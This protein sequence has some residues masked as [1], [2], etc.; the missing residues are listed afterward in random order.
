MDVLAPDRGCAAITVEGRTYHADRHG[1]YRGVP[2][3]HGRMMIRGGNAAQA[4]AGL[5]H[6]RGYLCGSCG[7]RAVF[8]T[9]GRC[10]AACEREQ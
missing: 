2:D 7:F 6:A 5:G 9:C 4:G 10:G 8:S 1:V 3:R